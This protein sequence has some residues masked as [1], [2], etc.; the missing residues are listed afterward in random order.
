MQ[1]ALPAAAGAAG[2]GGAGGA[3]GAR[4]AAVD[5]AVDAAATPLLSHG[6]GQ[7]NFSGGRRRRLFG[8]LVCLLFRA[9]L[10]VNKCQNIC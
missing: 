5:A 10:H 3:G 7:E 8:S 9:F 1:I 2:V 4:G 6:I